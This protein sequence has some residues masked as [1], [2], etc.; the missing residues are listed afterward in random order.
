M[1]QLPQEIL[2]HIFHDE[3]L[4]ISD[5]ESL[6]LVNKALAAAAAPFVFH[7][8]SVWF[9]LTSLERLT[10]IAEHHQLSSYV[11]QLIFSPLRF[12]EIS[13]IDQYEANVR[14]WMKYRHTSLG[15]LSLNLTRHVAAYRSY[16]D[17]QHRLTQKGEDLEILTW[18]LSKLSHLETF[19]FSFWNS[20]IGFHELTKA[21]GPFRAGDLLTCDPDHLLPVVVR[22]LSESQRK[23]KVFKLGEIEEWTGK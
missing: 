3:E 9:S 23:I 20:L 7:T 16:L 18:A 15:T 14:T 12:Q 13:D 2:Q 5:L 10:S 19:I 22:A 1:D 4:S 11:K 17:L 6:R 21:F 8:I